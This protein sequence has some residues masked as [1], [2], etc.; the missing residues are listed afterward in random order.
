MNDKM[1]N[2]NEEEKVVSEEAI[3]EIK[4]AGWENNYCPYRG[5]DQDE[6]YQHVIQNKDFYTFF[7]YEQIMSMAQEFI[8]NSFNMYGIKS[9]YSN[10]VMPIDLWSKCIEAYWE[11]NRIFDSMT[12]EDIHNMSLPTEDHRNMGL[13]SIYNMASIKKLNTIRSI[14]YRAYYDLCNI[15]TFYAKFKDTY[16][17]Y[18]DEYTGEPA[19]VLTV[20]MERMLLIL[21][22][23][24]ALF[25]MNMC[26]S[27]S[28]EDVSDDIKHMAQNITS[29]GEYQRFT[30]NS[31]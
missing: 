24:Q 9:K 22:K 27:N 11:S 3:S 30:P 13:Y 6:V 26:H 29:P 21:I 14:T 18:V 1:N 16:Q 2:I 8:T 7:L 17:P 23:T 4:A 31:R 10:I 28:Y 15:I 25:K 20:D 5:L 19:E 12:S